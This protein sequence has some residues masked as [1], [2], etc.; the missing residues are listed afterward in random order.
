SLCSSWSNREP[1]GRSLEAEL[2]AYAEP[3]ALFTAALDKFLLETEEDSEAVPIGERFCREAL[4]AS[5]F[6]WSNKPNP[7]IALWADLFVELEIKRLQWG[8]KGP[9]LL[10]AMEISGRLAKTTIPYEELFNAGL[11]QVAKDFRLRAQLGQIG[12]KVGYP[13]L[14]DELL[15]SL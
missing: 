10:K 5:F 6:A 8:D 1:E 7:R 9:Q 3:N 13:E 15:S 2:S 4:R 14:N 11:R 12:D